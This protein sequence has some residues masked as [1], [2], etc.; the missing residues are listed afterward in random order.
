MRDSKAGATVVIQFL[1]K[2]ILRGFESLNEKFKVVDDIDVLGALGFAL[3]ALE[4]LTGLAVTL[5]NQIVVELAVAFQFGELLH[6][7]VEAEVLG[8]SNLLWAALGAVMTGGARNGNSITNDLCRLGD[9]FLF[10]FIKRLE[11]LH[12]GRVILELLHVA[13]TAQH[14]HHIGL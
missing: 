9:N 5:G 12:I 11:I 3:T 2:R 4:A 1:K 7:V 13:H 10:L 14:H 8:D 6:D